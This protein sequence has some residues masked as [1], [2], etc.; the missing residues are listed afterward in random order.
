MKAGAPLEPTLRI[1]EKRLLQTLGYGIDLRAETISGRAASSRS[2]IIISGRGRAC[3]ASKQSTPDALAGRSLCSL[4]NEELQ[5][6]RALKDARTLLQ[7][8]LAHC[9]DGRE[10]ATRLVARSMA[11]RGS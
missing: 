5:D 9:L 2:G 3:S 1:F 8:A 6:A 10:L 11:R 4:A 7:A